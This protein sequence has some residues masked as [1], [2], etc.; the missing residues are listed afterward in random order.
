M[1][2]AAERY[3]FTFETRGTS[4]AVNA[5]SMMLCWTGIIGWWAWQAFAERRSG[6]MFQMQYSVYM[7]L[8]LGGLRLEDGGAAVLDSKLAE[9]S[10]EVEFLGEICQAAAHRRAAADAQARHLVHGCTVACARPQGCMSA[11]AALFA[12]PRRQPCGELQV[13]GV[14][15]VAVLAGAALDPA[16]GAWFEA[17]TIRMGVDAE[18]GSTV[19]SVLELLLG[20]DG[21]PGRFHVA[22]RND[23]CFS[24]CEHA[25]RDHAHGRCDRKPA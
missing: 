13:E 17:A 3:S 4:R 15:G 22:N 8:V 25:G 7:A 9:V 20:P 24:V 2:L 6:R 18:H 14:A 16:S 11:A 21:I 12:F 23:P 19:L 1:A 10:F 5:S